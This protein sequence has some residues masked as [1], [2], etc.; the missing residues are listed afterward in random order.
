M[1]SNLLPNNPTRVANSG[2]KN[3]A[4]LESDTI[5]QLGVERVMMLEIC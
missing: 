5:A 1:S 3:S 2:K 4:I